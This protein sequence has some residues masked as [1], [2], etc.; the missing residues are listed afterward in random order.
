MN[1]NL[2][3]YKKSGVD[4]NAAD[5]F[6]KFISN[7]STKNSGRKKFNNIGGFGSITN[8]PKNIK[9]PKIVACT[10][11]VGTKIEIANLLNKYNTIGIDLVAMSVNDLIVQG[12][13]PLFF[14][15]Y[16]SINKIDLSKLKSIIKGIVK[17]CKISDCDLVGGETA[18]M[19]GTYDKGKFD[20]AGFAVGI[21]E[22]NKI[23][24]KEKIKKNDLILAVPSSGLHSNG[25][26]L[27]R[28]LIKK[29]KIN[30]KNNQF[31]KK[32][33]IKPTK[34]YVKEVLKLIKK[35]FINGCANITGGGLADNI[36]RIIPE[37]LC[38]EINLK[39]IKPLKIFYWLKK[40]KISDKEMLKTFNCGVGFCLIIK[41]E[42][43]NKVIK[44]FPKKY[45]PYI[46][47]KI[48]NEKNK[49]KL[50]EKI[51]WY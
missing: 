12:A 4:I 38:A 40:N 25:Y 2:F 10:D 26:S 7:I 3:T 29:K 47:G 27:V 39:K 19:P 24:G 48:T 5:K 23:L 21:V 49:V 46:I 36:S 13:K 22:E 35:N 15:D 51:S 20:I 11:G 45:K 28:H 17:G 14:L 6:V 16:I 32:E 9:K 1:K 33:L 42:N 31:L 37:K 41:P 18:E 50:H 30:I 44:F 34:I 8:I 43:F